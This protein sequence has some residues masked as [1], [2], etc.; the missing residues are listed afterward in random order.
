M[1]TIMASS[2]TVIDIPFEQFPRLNVMATTVTVNLDNGSGL[3]GGDLVVEGGDGIYSYLW[4]DEGGTELGHEQTLLVEKAGSYY[5][6]VS[7]GQDCQVSTKFTVTGGNGIENLT[8]YGMHIALNKKQLTMTYETVPVQVRIINSAG[9]LER[10]YSQL[11]PS[12]L[13]EDVTNLPDGTY[14]VCVAFANG[15]AVVVKLKK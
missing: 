14:M 8:S 5:L 12:T 1:W 2:Q 3:L 11:P 13:T 15:E 10:V 9:L 4:T 7:D 6:I